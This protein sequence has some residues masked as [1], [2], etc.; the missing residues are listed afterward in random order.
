MGFFCITVD[1]DELHCYHAIHGLD[2]PESA[3]AQVVYKRAIPRVAQF[4]EDLKIRGTL[5]VVGRDLRGNPEAKSILR[6]LVG[7][8]HEIANHSMNHRYD[9]TLLTMDEQRSEIALASEVIREAVGVAPQGFR[10]PGYNIHMGVIE[11]L[12]QENMLYDSSVFPCPIYYSAKA[13]ALGIKS[14]K[15]TPSAS[16]MGDPRVL[17]APSVP[18]QIGEDGV[19][20]RGQ[21]MREF[22]VS[23]ITPARLPLVGT[24]LGMMGGF[25][26]S[27]LAK[28]SLGISFVNL[29][30]HG[31]DFVDADGDD[32]GYIK[33]YQRD[34]R[35]S[36][37]KRI[38]I[39]RRVVETLLEG[40]L[41]PVTLVDAAGRIFI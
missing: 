34:M 14:L 8:G 16:I 20:T 7:S 3:V 1:L 26:A 30:F 28:K 13:A 29:E 2:A 33:K 38:K 41:E 9:L 15:R 27:L 4:L 36:L 22:P 32:I 17:T 11:L 6:D 19:W 23:V 18:Y 24:F 21:G 5:F 39:Y 31:I 37:T 35:I 40:G 25:S 12:T 10:A